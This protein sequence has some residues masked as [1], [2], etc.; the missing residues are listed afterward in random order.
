MNV[1]ATPGAVARMG[2]DAVANALMH[3]QPLR[4]YGRIFK[5][6]LPPHMLT[7]QQRIELRQQRWHNRKRKYRMHDHRRLLKLRKKYV[8]NQYNGYVIRAVDLGR[9]GR[10]T[11]TCA[12]SGLREHML[13]RPS[14]TAG[15]QS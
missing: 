7:K 5:L 10:A 13:D 9:R 2:L 3:V 11:F 15:E 1:F 6:T 14:N 8:G 12:P 4:P